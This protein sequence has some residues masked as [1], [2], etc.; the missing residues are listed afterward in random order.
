MK[1]VITISEDTLKELIRIADDYLAGEYQ[2]E[3][4]RSYFLGRREAYQN[5]L[6]TFGHY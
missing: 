3:T 2:T 4:N 5:I 1:K 6:D